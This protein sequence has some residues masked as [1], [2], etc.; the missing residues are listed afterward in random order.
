MSRA[1]PKVVVAV[2]L[3]ASTGLI[4]GRM[5]GRW[6]GSSAVAEA[7]AR[8]DRIPEVVDGRVGTPSE[9][10]R[11]VLEKAGIAG[12]VARTYRDPRGGPA[13]TILLV[14]GR[15]GPISVHTPDVC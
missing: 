9:L 3:I 8:L 11:R 13:T 15:P 12:Y 10:D 5:T 6:S 7:I 1:L 4:H 14:C 2:A